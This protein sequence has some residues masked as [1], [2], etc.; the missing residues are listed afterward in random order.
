MTAAPATA[1]R[2]AVFAL[3]VIFTANFFSYL[4]RQLVSAV[5]RPIRDAIGLNQTEYGLL[6]TLFT[7]G[8][9]TFAVPIGFLADRYNRPR[10]LAACIVVWSIATVASGMAHDRPVL[11]VSRFLIGVGEAGCLVVGQSLIA[12]Y[13]EA[14]VRGRALS[15]FHLA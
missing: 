1:R 8:Y 9:M 10:I 11:Y 3:L 5:E 2:L 12:D 13:F 4:D 7:I 15:I 6:W 14:R